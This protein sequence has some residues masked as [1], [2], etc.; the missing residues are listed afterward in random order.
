MENE[1]KYK[2]EVFHIYG[3]FTYPEALEIASKLKCKLASWNQMMVA[4]QRGGN[5][6][7]YGWSLN[8]EAYYPIQQSY[9]DLLKKKGVSNNCGN[10]GVNGGYFKDKNLKFGINCYGLRPNLFSTAYFG[11]NIVEILKQIQ[12]LPE[13]SS[14]H[15]QNSF[16]NTTNNTYD[17]VFETNEYISQSKSLDKDNLLDDQFAPLT[18]S[19]YSA[20][21]SINKC[22]D[23]KACNYNKLGACSYPESDR[24]DCDGNNLYCED[25]KACNT[26]SEGSCSYPND[27]FTCDEILKPISLSLDTTYPIFILNKNELGTYILEDKDGNVVSNDTLQSYTL[28]SNQTTNNGY[29]L[30]LYIVIPIN[31]KGIFYI[32][33]GQENDYNTNISNDFVCIGQNNK[34]T[35]ESTTMDYE[36]I[37]TDNENNTLPSHYKLYKINLFNQYENYLIGTKNI[38]EGF[39]TLTVSQLFNNTAKLNK[40]LE[41]NTNCGSRYDCKGNTLFCT[42]PVACNYDEVGTCVYHGSREDCK[43]NALYCED[44]AAC[45]FEKLGS[46][47][48]PVDNYD[49]NGSLIGNSCPPNTELACNPGSSEKCWY[50]GQKDDRNA[51]YDSRV[52][53]EGNALYCESSDALN[54]DEYGSCRFAV[55]FDN[56]T[57]KDAVAEWMDDSTSAE[58]KYGHI[59]DWDVSQVTDMS[60]LF[61]GTDFNGDIIN[62]DVSNVTNMSNM[63]INASSFEQSLYNWVVSSV[64]NMSN[65]FKNAVKFNKSLKNWDVSNVTSMSSMFQGATSFN[66]P[67]KKWD[68]SSVTTMLGMFNSASA[69]NKDISNWDVSSVEVMQ[70]MFFNAE[71]FNKD[72]S[73]WNISSVTNMT[74]MFNGAT[75]FNSGYGN[76]FG[77]INTDSLFWKIN[78]CDDSSACNYMSTTEGSCYYEGR[79]DCE[80]NALYCADPTACNYNEMG[81]CSYHNS[82]KDCEG[83]LIYTIERFFGEQIKT[84]INNQDVKVYK[85]QNNFT[86]YED[87]IDDWLL[88]NSI[89]DNVIFDGNNKT[90]KYE[91]PG[92]WTGLFKPKDDVTMTIKNI[93][94]DLQGPLGKLHGCILGAS[95][96]S[97]TNSYDKHN[98]IIENCH[99]FSDASTPQSI[100][101]YGGGIVGQALGRSESTGTITNCSNKLEIKEPSAGGI[102]GAFTQSV[103]IEYCWNEGDILGNNAGGICGNVSK[104][105]LIIKY[106]YNKSLIKGSNAGGIAG[107]QCGKGTSL[108][109]VIFNCYHTGNGNGDDNSVN[110]QGGITGGSVAAD[111]GNVNIYNCWSSGSDLADGI[112]GSKHSSGTVNVKNCYYIG[113]SDMIYTDNTYKTDEW[114]DTYAYYTIGQGTETNYTDVRWNNDDG[115]TEWLIHDNDDD[116]IS[117]TFADKYNLTF[118][119]NTG[120]GKSATL[121]DLKVIFG[122]DKIDDTTT[123]NTYKLKDNI[124]IGPNKSVYFPI[125]IE[126]GITF[127]GGDN[128]IKYTGKNAWKGLFYVVSGTSSNKIN[129]TVKN[130]NFVLNGENIADYCGGIIRGQGENNE[131]DFKSYTTI[132]VKNCHISS[133]NSKVIGNSAGGIVGLGFCCGRNESGSITNCSNKLEVKGKGSGGI[134]GR[135]VSKTKIQY[136]WNEGNISGEGCGGICGSGG[137]KFS[138]SGTVYVL[139]TYCYN[140]GD[141][142]NTQVGGI[143]G[144]SPHGVNIFNCYNTGTIKNTAYTNVGGIVGY[145]SLVT[146]IY[147]CYSSPGTSDN[148]N[149]TGTGGISAAKWSVGF[150]KVYNCYY[151]Y[152]SVKRNIFGSTPSKNKNNVETSSWDD[153]YAY[154]TIGQGTKTN[155]TDVRWNNDDVTE[156][157]IN[158]D[159]NTV[160]GSFAGSYTLGTANQG[161]DDTVWGDLEVLFGSAF[162]ITNSGKTCTLTRS[163]TIDSSVNKNTFPIPMPGDGTNIYK[164]DGGYDS[165]D[166]SPITITIDSSYGEKWSGIFKPVAGAK[167]NIENVN[168][169]IN[170]TIA[171]NCGALIGTA[172]DDSLTND[173][174][175]IGGGEETSPVLIKNC[176]VKGT[177]KTPGGGGGLLGSR[178]GYSDNEYFKIENCS[179]SLEIKGSNSGGICGVRVGRNSNL[180]ILNCKNVGEISG[181]NSGGICGAYAGVSGLSII[182]KNCQNV[183]EIS[184]NYAGGIC[185][186][187]VSMEST[188]DNIIEYCWNEGDL[189][190]SGSGGIIGGASCYN[191]GTLLVQYCY[192]T[193]DFTSGSRQGGICGELAGQKT[194]EVSIFNCY[195][196]SDG[197][198]SSKAQGGICGTGAGSDNNDENYGTVYVFNCWV[199]GT[200]L[201]CGIVSSV[202]SGSTVEVYNCYYVGDSD[203]ITSST[204]DD[205]NLKS[206]KW[207]EGY[208]NKTINSD[209]ELDTI[210][211][212][213]SD[214]QWYD[215]FNDDSDL[216]KRYGG[217]IE[218]MSFQARTGQYSY[219]NKNLKITLSDYKGDT[220]E[221]RYVGDDG[222]TAFSIDSYDNVWWNLINDNTFTIENYA[223]IDIPT[224]KISKS[225]TS[226]DVLNVKD[227]YVDYVKPDG[228]SI[229]QINRVKTGVTL[230]ADF[231]QKGS[232]KTFGPGEYTSTK[233]INAGVGNDT[234]SSLFIESGYSVSLYRHDNFDTYLTDSASYTGPRGVNLQGTNLRGYK[235][236]D[237]LS[238]FKVFENAPPWTEIDDYDYI[239]VNDTH[240]TRYTTDSTYTNESNEYKVGWLGVP[241]KK[242]WHGSEGDTYAQIQFVN[243]DDP[244]NIITPRPWL[245]TDW[246]TTDGS[247]GD[248]SFEN[249]QESALGE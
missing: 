149:G 150:L 120:S 39:E 42:D 19:N 247:W 197:T 140:R 14:K 80:G 9:Y 177:A 134:C 132:I 223:L 198:D 2:E 40:L 144:Y 224:I 15:N 191:G 216:K 218:A 20:P 87:N 10:P 148:W 41:I 23:S 104:G 189:T 225:D 26:G 81:D 117:A 239:L 28:R 151:I 199:Q 233:M 99:T 152:G 48:N 170:R 157:L 12:Y 175:Q 234:V 215:S 181:Q 209:N 7:S 82:K 173:T 59:S 50:P 63:F 116:T 222:D 217:Y 111:F 113:S 147:N 166:A 145:N 35:I 77:T 162:E 6:C 214:L 5:W 27:G 94:F 1:R 76:E 3:E 172:Y 130:I 164:F 18:G 100:N 156:W 171:V 74:S 95:Y 78:R 242:G 79:E 179:N 61:K 127:D 17:Y 85:L 43:G 84:S 226:G 240:T 118:A 174:I 114:D 146:N 221:S 245:I 201:G 60:E 29:E 31:F 106:C 103:I 52:D 115:V 89:Q 194:G 137:G 185:G 64:T 33:D 212:S 30:I 210:D 195:S 128:T 72:I 139:I 220:F 207:Y 192:N 203:T 62:W 196:I 32:V 69:F 136:C 200:N 204:K 235:I 133:E 90:I 55:I 53:C 71:A 96:T 248:T 13:S 101:E 73:D 92:D 143:C 161:D 11:N 169:I 56:G 47:E 16:I 211:K 123:S 131:D 57:L 126:D 93:K 219:R 34:L 24:V 121:S 249:D 180:T 44:P 165:S 135:I 159:G 202:I 167:L 183:G 110:N 124:T 125:A 21:A 51:A 68:V 67:L 241:Y 163:I 109:P 227:V 97:S 238:S 231:N 190:G 83:E 58:F 107:S 105:S 184:G 91:G 213:S 119:N 108:G 88:I 45:N 188:G 66:Q 8:Q 75:E 86:F 65:M 138:N 168:I 154:Y 37:T 187:A 54:Y 228:S 243:P 236:N 38:E 237:Q 205:N 112:V 230:Y 49:C 158:N 142:G 186:R 102:C 193:A 208:A 141:L 25:S 46:C 160:G 182:V 229:G 70:G 4:H 178:Y 153:T 98:V 232:N 155:Y 244:D 206:D 22:E 122:D 129:F 176:H 246:L 36:E